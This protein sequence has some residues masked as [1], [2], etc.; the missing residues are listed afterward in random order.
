MVMLC[1]PMKSVI[2]TL[3]GYLNVSVIILENCAELCCIY[4]LA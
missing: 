3:C 1:A 2:L 4:R